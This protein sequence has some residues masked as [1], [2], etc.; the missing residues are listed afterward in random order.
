MY[1]SSIQVIQLLQLIKQSFYSNYCLEQGVY[2]YGFLYFTRCPTTFLVCI[3]FGNTP[4]TLSPTTKLSN[5]TLQDVQ[6]VASNKADLVKSWSVRTFKVIKYPPQLM[7]NSS[8]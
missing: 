8:F 7:A 6:Q 2:I 4:T 5:I 1:T 3:G